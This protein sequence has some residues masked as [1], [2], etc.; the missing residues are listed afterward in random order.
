LFE[1]EKFTN[2]CLTAIDINTSANK[3]YRLNHNFNK[4]CKLLECNIESLT[5]LD[6]DRMNLDLL[7]MSPPCQPFSRLGNQLDLQDS[8]SSSFKHLMQLFPSMRNKPRFVMLENVKGFET[9][10]AHQLLISTLRDCK[11]RIR[12]F[13]LSP[14]QFGVPNSRLRYYLLA[15]HQPEKFRGDE[16]NEISTQIP[17]LMGNN[18]IFFDQH[19]EY[20]NKIPLK[21]FSLEYY[22]ENDENL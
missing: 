16:I 5:S 21:E 4:D 18:S 9:S 17:V 12:E 3:V 7:T 8:R 19:I 6:F 10:N 14:D 13:L 22:L 1:A 15:I 2:Y 11:Y 20:K